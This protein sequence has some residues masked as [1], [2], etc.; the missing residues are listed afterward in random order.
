MS[1]QPDKLYRLAG[2]DYDWD[3]FQQLAHS[4]R[5]ADGPA[6]CARH[7]NSYT[8]GLSPASPPA[9]TRGRNPW[10]RR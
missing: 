2:V 6:C 7:W 1:T 9:G 8:D 5:A 4:S 10:P 3:R